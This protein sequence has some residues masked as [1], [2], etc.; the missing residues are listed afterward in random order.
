MGLVRVMDS[1]DTVISLVLLTVTVL[2]MGS[3]LELGSATPVSVI[4]PGNAKLFAQ[5]V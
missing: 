3:A 1:E 5:I 2:D 4:I